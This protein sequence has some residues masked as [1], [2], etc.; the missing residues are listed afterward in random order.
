MQL[1]VRDV[2]KLLRV[3]ENVVYRWIADNELPAIEVNG[4]HRF[5]CAEILEWATTRKMAIEPSAFPY[6]NG[7]AGQTPC[8]SEALRLGGILYDVPGTEVAG[9]LRYIIDQMPLPDE[10]E[11]DFLLQVF[12]SREAIGSTAVGDGIALPH[13]RYPNVVQV[14]D[15]F[16]TLAFLKQPIPYGPPGTPPVHTLFALVSPAVRNHLGLL[17]VLATALRDGGFRAAVAG[18]RPA[19]EILQ[20]AAALE[21]SIQHN[22]PPASAAAAGGD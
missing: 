13:P 12:L 19:V 21:A 8:L 5:N 1:N 9:V 17:A 7:N 10:M 15:P 6:S 11:R 14:S 20:C 2:A 22:P 4:Q 16:I 3:K 18:R